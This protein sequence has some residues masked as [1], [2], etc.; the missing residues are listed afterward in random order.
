MD[1]K[2]D[3]GWQLHPIGG[4]TGQA[5]MG[6]REKEKVFLKRNSSPFLAALS[7]EGIT[8][9]LIWTKRAGNG[10]V[11]TAQEWLNGRSL[12]DEEMSNVEVATLLKQI[13]QSPTLLHML[14]RVQGEDYNPENF[15]QD[16]LT[17]LQS[18]LQTHSFLNQVLDYL[19][20]T[21]YLIN[22]S[23][24]T[25][26][27]GD[28]NRRNFMWSDQGRLYLVDWEMVKLADPIS[29]LTM[30]LVQYVPVHQWGDWLDLY[31]VHISTNIYQR[32]EW[33][34]LMNCLFLIKKNHFDGRYYEMNEKIL[35]VKSIFENRIQKEE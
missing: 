11:I 6:T 15:I 20:D 21:M 25:V 3:S 12:T 16:Y 24:K 18:G 7:G 4:D 33:Y 19:R 17:N 9:R 28:L 8:P 23:G 1:Y 32:I 5:Y 10:D 26:C 2:M 35:L 29:D 13:H 27:H 30:I 14:Q 34:S 31:G 22:E